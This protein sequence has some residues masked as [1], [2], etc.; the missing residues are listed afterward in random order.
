MAV[1]GE[2]VSSG[3]GH[4]DD[5]G[6]EEDVEVEHRQPLA[7]R[8][9]GQMTE[10]V[11]H[12]QHPER[13]QDVGANRE[14]NKPNHVEG[15][16]DFRV[17]PGIFHQIVGG[18]QEVCIKHQEGRVGHQEK[19]ESF[20]R[21]KTEAGSGLVRVQSYWEKIGSNQDSSQFG[22]E[23]H[24][25]PLVLSISCC[26]RYFLWFNG[27]IYLLPDFSTQSAHC[28]GILEPD[29]VVFIF[30]NI[31]HYPDLLLLNIVPSDCSL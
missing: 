7:Q 6:V 11:R 13:S 5:R 1:V 2:T 27:H 21:E 9:L 24:F 8:D 12:H 31:N 10:S 15:G 20:Q 26:F 16:I 14:Q 4:S 23:A 18:K 25:L 19:G 3:D 17:Y 29:I 30:I 28:T 22:Q